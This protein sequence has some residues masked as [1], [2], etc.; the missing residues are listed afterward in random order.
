MRSAE[1]GGNVYEQFRRL[2][3]TV[4][5]QAGTVVV[6]STG[7]ATVEFPGGGRIQARNPQGV[8]AGQRVFVR[9]GVIEGTA[10]NL[11]IEIIEI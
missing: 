7:A 4:S 5:L 11:T 3:P 2:I 10:P 6:A 9:D 1:R 8:P